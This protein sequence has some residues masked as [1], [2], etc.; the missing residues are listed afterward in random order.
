VV[1]DKR[2]REIRT[3]YSSLNIQ[4]RDLATAKKNILE[5]K[6]TKT[7]ERIKEL[8]KGWY[9]DGYIPTLQGSGGHELVKGGIP[10]K[11]M[12]EF[13]REAKKPLSER[14]AL[15][16]SELPD[17]LKRKIE[18]EGITTENVDAL[19]EGEAKAMEGLGFKK[20]DINETIDDYNKIKE[21]LENEA[22]GI[23]KEKP[24]EAEE[25]IAEEGKEVES[26][27]T[28]AKANREI[29]KKDIEKAD[30]LARSG[31]NLFGLDITNKKLLNFWK[32]YFTSR[33]LLPE[34]VFNDYLKTKGKIKARL[35]EIDFVRREFT[36]AARKAYGKTALGTPKISKIE[37][38]KINGVLNELR[39]T[40]RQ[41]IISE[42]PEGIQTTIEFK[43]AKPA[44]EVLNQIP[45]EL[46]KVIIKMRNQI[47]ALSREMVKEG[48]VEG[49]LAM[50]FMDNLGFYLTRTYKIHNDKA[51]RW[52]KIP[53]EI[54]NRAYKVLKEEI[55]TATNEEINGIMRGMVSKDAPFALI[56]NGKLGAKDLGILMKR[57]NIHEAIRALKGEYKDP[58]YNYATS[59]A[60]MASLV[61]KSNFLR[62]VKDVGMNKFL[63]E[64][65]KGEFSEQIA[66]EASNTMSPLN[67]LYTTPEIKKAFEQFERTE[68]IS[69]LGRTY[70]TGNAGVKYG[71]TVLSPQ[72]HVRNYISWFFIHMATGKNPFGFLSTTQKEIRNKISERVQR[73]FTEERKEYVKELL[74][75]NVIDESVW[76]GEMH[77][78]IKDS[79][80]YYE[81]FDRAGDNYFKKIAKGGFKLFEKFYK[82]EDNVNKIYFY[83]AEKQQYFDAYSKQYPGKSAEEVM[84]L[85]R[86]KASNITVNTSPTYSMVSKA[87]KS[88]RRFF[89]VGTFVSFPAEIFRTTYNII[90]LIAEEMRNPYTKHI[91]IKRLA[92]L[93]SAATIVPAAA[94]LTRSMIGIGK[95]EDRDIRRFLPE[96]SEDSDLFFLN[97][98]NAGSYTYIDLG[99][100]DPHNYIRK[101]L[102][103]LVKD[104][105]DL[106]SGK[107][108]DIHETMIRS[109]EETF[110]PFLGEELLAS[111]LGDLARNSKKDTGQQVYNPQLPLGEQAKEMID[112]L[113]EGVK[114]GV[115]VSGERIK[116][117]AKGMLEG[118]SQYDLA[119]EIIAVVTG[120][121]IS[122]L[123]VNKAFWWK[124]YRGGKDLYE[125]RNIYTSKYKNET[126]E[127]KEIDKAYKVANESLENIIT[128]L[129]K[130]YKA[131]I[132]LG[133]DP[134]KLNE[135][136]DKLYMG[137]FPA[138]KLIKEA[139]KT[140]K[141]IPMD[142]EAKFISKAKKGKT[143]K[144]MK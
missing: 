89:L 4:T 83:E 9:K 61:E 28:K 99:Y 33:G 119:N 81:D 57:K 102:N 20:K 84:K 17:V 15:V 120:Q 30:V 2:S 114:P 112:Y 88:V 124:T 139:I 40:D 11:D 62:G 135:T 106:I 8:I 70:L 23:E 107:D 34:E 69:W 42:L 29:A 12:I 133:V 46:H 143:G 122:T 117:G 137:S 43:K 75:Q 129:H 87:I 118:S 49:D 45:E 101:V 59:F 103:P 10:V 125:A 92:G 94:L 123:D 16:E 53:D 22:K 6:T 50:K 113:W 105:V 108:V 18:D 52:E 32:E 95:D 65:P 31:F 44:E 90:P 68:A 134:K 41:E 21:Y 7:A 97:N 24:V 56:R 64:K 78:I 121:R 35:K 5:G 39:M 79:Y 100:S 58:L 130:D 48:I 85:A 142:K 77:D 98:K 13:M 54:K 1:P 3:D 110:K 144:V 115:L 14:D 91:G 141:Y 138:N 67:G 51:W 25:R 126:L 132:R 73:G 131:A 93:M 111:K 116:K 136:I 104:F 74:E 72:T 27:N 60:K 71:K 66:A 82:L 37:L 80:K 26:L 19:R 63:F 96:W 127:Q 47:D 76:A 55:P 140:G 86:E 128:E 36:W 109:L 38:E